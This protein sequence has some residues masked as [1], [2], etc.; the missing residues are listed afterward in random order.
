MRDHRQL[1]YLEEEE[2]EQEEKKKKKKKQK[3]KSWSTSS[4]LLTSVMNKQ[5]AAVE[6]SS[7]ISC[8][9]SIMTDA[10]RCITWESLFPYVENLFRDTN[11]V[12][13]IRSTATFTFCQSQLHKAAQ[14]SDVSAEKFKQIWQLG[15][16]VAQK[17]W[18][19]A[20]RQLMGMYCLPL[21]EH[22]FEVVNYLDQLE[23]TLNT[24]TGRVPKREVSGDTIGRLIDRGHNS[25]RAG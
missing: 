4:L 23:D 6:R 9:I 20:L 24:A 7:S 15:A 17:N 8:I 5:Q 18:I 3:K 22:S 13:F 12:T 1:Q 2:E 25:G 21:M 11:Y 14:L 16:K 19:K 10:V